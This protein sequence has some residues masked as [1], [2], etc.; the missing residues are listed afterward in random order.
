MPG[1]DKHIAELLPPPKEALTSTPELIPLHLPSSLPENKCPLVCV[2][3]IKEIED[4]L[5]FAQASEALNKLR[6]QLMKRTY[7]TRYK[8]RNNVSGQCHYTRFRTLQEH[9]ESKIKAACRQY[10]TG[11][12]LRSTPIFLFPLNR[13]LYTSS[14]STC[15][16]DSTRTSTSTPSTFP[17]CSPSNSSTSSQSL[18]PHSPQTSFATTHGG[19]TSRAAARRDRTRP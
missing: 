13:H 5:H 1:L 4:R 17:A 11:R 18:R 10:T 6:C 8:V 16:I 7:T 15:T 2:P 14:T 3:G 19:P 9:T 12:L